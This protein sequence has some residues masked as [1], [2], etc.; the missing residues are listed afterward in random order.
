[1]RFGK[2]LTTVTTTLSL[3]GILMMPVNTLAQAVE[4][5]PPP[6]DPRPVNFPKPVERTLSNGLRVIVINRG[7]TSLA[8]AQLLI[9]N[10]GE[11]DP[12]ERADSQT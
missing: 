10:G 3:A 5:P 12:A 2:I 4:Q 11:V 7:G 1:M 8:T 9:K 6:A